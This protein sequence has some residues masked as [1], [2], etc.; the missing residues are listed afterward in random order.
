MDRYELKPDA[1]RHADSHCKFKATEQRFKCSIE[2]C[3]KIYGSENSRER[4]EKYDC[5]LNPNRIVEEHKC[6]Q[7]DN[8][9]TRKDSL[10]RHVKS[11]HPKSEPLV[12]DGVVDYVCF[13]LFFCL[14]K[15]FEIINDINLIW[16][17]SFS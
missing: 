17:T 7:C 14:K 6:D 16:C 3:N 1:E 12:D 4:H 10:L 15:S 13:S 9:Y 11:A 8:T 5:L 2:G